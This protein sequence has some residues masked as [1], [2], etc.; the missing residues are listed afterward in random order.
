MCYS[1]ESRGIPFASTAIWEDNMTRYLIQG[2][3]TKEGLTGLLK[4][5]GS[6]RRQAA[7][8]QINGL[9]GTLEAFYFAF[10]HN[11]FYCIVDLPDNVIAAATA[12][13]GNTSGGMR[14]KTVV[15]LTPEEIDLAVKKSV[16]HHPPGQQ[17]ET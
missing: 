1:E 5:G 13:A 14:V 6:K 12:I 3:Y 15:L 4:E 9:G 7:E 8:K 11:D 10:G 2:S 16:D 17:L